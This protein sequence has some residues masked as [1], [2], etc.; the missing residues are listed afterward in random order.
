MQRKISSNSLRNL[1]K[2]NQEANSLT[3]EALETALLY[4]LQRKELQK[5]SIAELV[6]T[7][8]VSRNAFYRN[9][10]SKEEILSKHFGKTTK[11]LIFAWQS[12]SQRSPLSEIPTA[13][14]DFIHQQKG[15][16]MDVPAIK[17]MG[18]YQKKIKSGLTPLQKD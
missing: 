6:R 7:A 11:K 12:F 16:L 3:K 18:F 17:K 8:G 1:T 2:S 14:I 9:Y 15:R 5:I 4:L 10:K 13:F